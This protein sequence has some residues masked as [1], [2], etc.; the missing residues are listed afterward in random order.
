MRG[1]DSECGRPPPQ[2]RPSSSASGRQA[3]QTLAKKPPGAPWQGAGRK[4]RGFREGGGPSFR[5]PRCVWGRGGESESGELPS[6]APC[7][8]RLLTVLESLFPAWVSR[9]LSVGAR[10]AAGGEL[11]LGCPVSPWPGFFLDDPALPTL[12]V[13]PPRGWVVCR[14]HL[15]RGAHNLLLP[16]PTRHPAWLLPATACSSRWAGPPPPG[17]SIYSRAPRPARPANI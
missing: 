3:G 8:C 14:D 10:M 13:T 4:G 17:L 15:G 12:L 5:K 9:G 6:P 7:P 11:S 2:D 16:A 1:A